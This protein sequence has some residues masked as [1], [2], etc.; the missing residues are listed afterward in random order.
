VKLGPNSVVV[1]EKWR[2]PSVGKHGV[3]MFFEDKKRD[4]RN[5]RTRTLKS[6]M[7]IEDHLKEYKVKNFNSD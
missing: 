7:F 5:G 4:G 2:C 3:K 6:K 1:H